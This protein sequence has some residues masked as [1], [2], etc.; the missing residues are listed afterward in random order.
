MLK[1]F[2]FAHE[3][4][5]GDAWLARFAAGRKE[6]EAWYLGD[7]SEPPPTANECRNALRQHMPELMPHYDHVCALVGDDS[8]AH[9]ILS[10]YRPPPV[11]PGCTQAVWLGD[12]GPALIRNYDFPLDIVSGRFEATAWSKREVIAA[13]Q[14][15]WGGCLDGINDDGLVVSLTF[16]GSRARG[17]GFSAILMLRYILETCRNVDQATVALIRLPIAMAHNVTV[18]DRSGAYA[19]L[20]LGPG[21]AP[22]ISQ[23]RACANHQETAGIVPGSVERQSTTLQALDDEATTLSSLTAL[24]LAPPLY[25][26]AARSPT[27]Y[28]AVYR[29]AEKRVDYLWPGHCVEHRIG[30]FQEGEYTHD[31]GVLTP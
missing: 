20:F 3:E 12:E 10:H 28:S 19:T 5:P 8:L 29:P 22:A 4:R 17:R 18:L 2:V 1:R 21:R 23:I 30:N 24:F 7:G 15:P 27:A 16:G 25:S 6:T 9:S 13:A 26:R 11:V 14:R 31:Y